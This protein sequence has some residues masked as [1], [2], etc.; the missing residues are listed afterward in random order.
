LPYIFRLGPYILLL[1]IGTV[2]V[3][4]LVIAAYVMSANTLV[5]LINEGNQSSVQLAKAL[6]EREFDHWQESIH[7]HAKFQTLAK[8]VADGDIAIVCERLGVIVEGYEGIER[9]FVTD[10]QGNLWADF[11]LAP[12]SIGRNFSDRDWFRGVSA[13]YQPYVSEVYRRNAS[14]PVNVVA[15][16]VPVHCPDTGDLAG[17]LVAQLRLDALTAILASVEVGDGGQVILLD[18]NGLTAAHPKLDLRESPYLG[19]AD[20]ASDI[21]RLGRPAQE[22][23][24]E[25]PLTTVRMLA[26]AEVVSVAGNPWV[27]IAQQPAASAYSSRNLLALQLS[28]AGVLMI[29]A[30]GSLMFGLVRSFAGTRALN[31]DLDAE[32]RQ[33]KTAEERLQSVNENLE[34]RV[35]AR[36]AELEEA[37][38]RLLQ[39]QKLEAI[40][41][42]AGGIAHDFNNLLSV[43]IGYT[44]LLLKRL[45]PED[46]SYNVIQQV[47]EAGNRAAGLTRQLLSFSR[48]QVLKSRVLNVNDILEN[49]HAMLKRLIGEHIRLEVTYA[50]DLEPVYFDEGQLEQIIMNLAI[51]ARDAMPEGGLIRVKTLNVELD[52]DECRRHPGCSPGPH[53]VLVVSDTGVGMPPEVRD[54]IFEPFFTTKE[55]GRGTGLGLSTVYGIVQQADGSIWV[56]SEPGE[57]TTFKIYLPVT[58]K[59]PTDRPRTMRPSARLPA[60][61]GTVLV[62]EDEE[63]VRSL[64]VDLLES[65]GYTVLSCEDGDAAVQAVA[66]HAGAVHLLITDVVLPGM[67]GPEVARRLREHQPGLSVIY[68]SGYTDDTILHHGVED[69]ELTFIEKPIRPRELLSKVHTAL[70][71][72][73]GE[74]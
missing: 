21:Q 6:V 26:S 33:R 7:A 58:D 40:G 43:I 34:A 61:S 57:G 42:L 9:A 53:V 68:M 16:A 17:L 28:I 3:V 32:N 29:L 60:R 19:Y 69:D 2:P 12:E 4:V 1:L 38:D 59:E 67:R 74:G 49:M 23:S 36:N 46:E 27:V 18:H 5:R 62:V 70:T 24:Y 22:T 39:A 41:A 8:G 44:E 30:M 48:K 64:V 56:Y 50:P 51:N 71:G 52:E 65:S 63:A 14:P 13:E 45:P 55:L 31:R 35:E 11:P 25:D 10:L 66:S 20:K 54:K 73:S 37:R 72:D 15:V 47:H